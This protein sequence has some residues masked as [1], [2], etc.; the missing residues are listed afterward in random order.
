MYTPTMMSAPPAMR[1]YRL[2]IQPSRQCHRHDR[3]QHHHISGARR[4]PVLDHEDLKQEDNDGADCGD[5]ANRQPGFG[6]RG[7]GESLSSEQSDH[8]ENWHGDRHPNRV[9]SDR[10]DRRQATDDDQRPGQNK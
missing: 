10:M 9:E 8:K 5:V 3:D 6:E 4:I 2:L 7:H 1:R